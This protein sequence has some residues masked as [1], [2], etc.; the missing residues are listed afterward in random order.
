[1]SDPIL[2]KYFD[3]GNRALANLTLASG[4]RVL[5]TVVDGEERYRK[6]ET[7]WHGLIAA[8]RRAR[9][10]MLASSGSTRAPT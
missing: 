4:E 1:M 2:H 6:D 3:L 10:R 9:A 5:L 7:E 8:A